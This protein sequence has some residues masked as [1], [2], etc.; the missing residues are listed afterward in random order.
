[1]TLTE[2]MQGLTFDGEDGIAL[3]SAFAQSEAARRGILFMGMT[4]SGKTTAALRLTGMRGGLIIHCDQPEKV[5]ALARWQDWGMPDKAILLDELGRDS[6]VNEFGNRR[7]I[8]GGFIR[9]V[10]AAWKEGVWT[11]RIYATTNLDA[12]GLRKAYDES[13]V[14]R[15]AELCVTCKFKHGRR[16]VANRAAPETAGSTGNANRTER[17]GYAEDGIDM[18][19]D[20]ASSALWWNV[21]RKGCGADRDALRILRVNLGVFAGDDCERFRAC[22]N[23]GATGKL[24][25][26]IYEAFLYGACARPEAAERWARGVKEYVKAAFASTPGARDGYNPESA[27]G[28]EGWVVPFDF[29]KMVADWRE[30]RKTAVRAEE[31]VFA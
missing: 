16:V 5:V 15:L 29:G 24:S 27:K 10:Y 8:V 17:G 7:D 22:R 1:V 23:A 21:T 20:E 6:V 31:G 28:F 3:S 12:D 18:A 4:G 13:V 14:G 30:S 25:A 19:S 11:G 9:E 2:A 26:F